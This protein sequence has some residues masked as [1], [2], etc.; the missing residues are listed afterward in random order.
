M[1]VAAADQHSMLECTL[2]G[3]ADHPIVHGRTQ[4][5]RRQTFASPSRVRWSS[6]VDSTIELACTGVTHTVRPEQPSLVT[7]GLSGRR[8]GRWYRI[9]VPSSGRCSASGPSDL[10]APNVTQ[11]Y[12]IQYA[13]TTSQHSAAAEPSKKQDASHDSSLHAPRRRGGEPERTK[14]SSLGCI[15]LALLACQCLYT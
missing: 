9:R 11:M 5:H 12:H 1:F 13:H 14:G 6:A 15:H 8:H 10:F 2:Y 7:R 4:S 3:A